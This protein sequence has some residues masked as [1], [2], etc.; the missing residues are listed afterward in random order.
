M[1]RGQA[2]VN[3][4]TCM[5]SPRVIFGQFLWEF[6]DSI[7]AALTHYHVLARKDLFCSNSHP[8]ECQIVNVKDDD[9]LK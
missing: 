7:V 5:P 8:K 3:L 2:R 4:H 6:R 9:H 1:C